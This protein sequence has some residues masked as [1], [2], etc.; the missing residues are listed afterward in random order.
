MARKTF[1]IS[2]MFLMLFCIPFVH[3][4]VIIGDSSQDAYGV[5]IQHPISGGTSFNTTIIYNN[6][7]LNNTILNNTVF[8]NTIYNNTNV[9][10]YN[11]SLVNIT[12]MI[13]GQM[14]NF[15]GWINAIVSNISN[16]LTAVETINTTQIA[17]NITVTTLANTKAFPGE[18]PDGEVVNETTTTGVI[19]VPITAPLKIYYPETIGIT[20]GTNLTGPINLT[21]WYD[22]QT[23]NL[24]EGNGVNPLTLY[25][26]YSGVSTFNQWVTR[27]YYLGSS[28]HDIQFE[29]YDYAI[30]DWESYYGIVGQSDQTIISVPVFDPDDHIINGTVQTRYRHIQNGIAAHRFYVDFAWLVEGTDIGASTNLQGYAKYNYGTNN[31]TGTGNISATSF[32]G[33]LNWS[34]LENVPAYVLTTDLNDI[35]SNISNILTAVETI[36]TTQRADNSSMTGWISAIVSNISNF[37]GWITAIGL[38]LSYV[39][40]AVETVNTTQRADNS[41]L[42]ASIESKVNLS[43]T[44]LIRE[45]NIAMR[46]ESNNFNN[47]SLLGI[48]SVYI[49]NSI[50][51]NQTNNACM[52]WNGTSIII[53]NNASGFT[54][55]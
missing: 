30:N 31:F 38:N 12:V 24:T 34:W 11:E 17:D 40:T 47:N 32:S 46:N 13:T 48:G 45:T 7:I 53:N 4:E 55:R 9:Y 44:R 33:N 29:I 36:N 42:T 25:I 28:S 2:M 1:F 6:T 20:G 18:C 26:N 39:K 19:C 43:D 51:L 10:F 21:Y 8:N 15:T 14:F 54:C 3:A 50:W 23:Y 52:Y 22:S 41:T 16:I 37:P 49:Y 27:E 35:Q 5:V